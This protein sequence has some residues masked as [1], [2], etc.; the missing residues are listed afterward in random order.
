MDKY[1]YFT[2]A[3]DGTVT[4]TDETGTG[5]NL[6][7]NVSIDSTI[8]TVKNI[9][10]AELPESGGPGTTL[11][12]LIGSILLLGCGTILVARRRMNRAN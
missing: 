4:L 3:S 10:G 9:P 6:N 5:P 11:I 12:Y 8:L 2:V 1:V 7:N